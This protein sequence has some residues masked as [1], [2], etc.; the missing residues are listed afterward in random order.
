MVVPVPVIIGEG[1]NL[2]STFLSKR[3]QTRTR[4]SSSMSFISVDE[5]A[6]DVDLFPSFF[7]G[8]TDTAF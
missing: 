7:H 4:R 8:G 1:Q 5:V 2:E 6:V 3:C